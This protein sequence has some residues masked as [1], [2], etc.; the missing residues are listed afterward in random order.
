[1]G[2]VTIGVKSVQF[3]PLAGDGGPGTVFTTLGFTSKGTLS[4]NEE[5]PTKKLVEV[6]ETSDPIGIFK[7]PAPR[8][9]TLSLANPDLDTLA[10]IRGGT[11]TAGTGGADDKYTEDS[12]TSLVGTI[13]IEFKQGF[14][15]FIYNH[16][17]I[18]GRFSGNV[19]DD[20]ELLLVLDVDVLT[21]TK[22]GVKTFEVAAASGS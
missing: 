10:K 3:A 7:R 6:E 11:K 12:P 4:F 20:Q 17:S 16:V 21:P 2:L 18:D 15:S 22:S 9:F 19:G 13:K 8:T 14:K 1:M 5:A